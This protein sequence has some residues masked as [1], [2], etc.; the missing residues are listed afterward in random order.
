[1]IHL[2]CVGDG[3]DTSVLD[4]SDDS[5]SSSSS[6]SSASSTSTEDLNSAQ[7]KMV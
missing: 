5:S 4:D 3:E 2:S 7:S 1:M 6:R